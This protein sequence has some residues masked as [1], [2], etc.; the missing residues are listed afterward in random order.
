MLFLNLWSNCSQSESFFIGFNL[1]Y[2]LGE[3]ADLVPFYDTCGKSTHY[4]NDKHEFSIFIPRCYKD[5]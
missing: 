4:S 5:V 2:V 3:L 1:E